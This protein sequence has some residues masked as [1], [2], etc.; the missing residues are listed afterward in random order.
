MNFMD[1][2]RSLVLVLAVACAG[3]G[4]DAPPVADSAQSGSA[5]QSNSPS[6]TA[7]G[8]RSWTVTERGYG[9]VR[10]GTTLD[11]AR[12]AFGDSLSISA[13][14]DS[15]CDH[16]APTFT[17]GADPSVLFMIE[18][19]RIARVEVRDSS[20]ATSAGVRVGDLRARVE[21]LYAG[22]VRVRPH[23][24]TDGHYLIVPLGTGPDS[25]SRLVFETDE[26]GRV[27][28]FRAGLYPQ[29]EW[30]EGCA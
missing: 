6:T 28:T 4:G 18:Q 24:Y 20:I 12:T 30:V 26:K 22:R 2:P 7:A 10:A 16:V 27:S 9:P 25:L 15:I 29:V 3:S 11:E 5:Q 14:D 19:G 17:K 23:K 8:R 1:F 21:S 13:P